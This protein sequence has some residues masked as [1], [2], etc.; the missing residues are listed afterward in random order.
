MA[1]RVTMTIAIRDENGVQFCTLEKVSDRHLQ[2]Q[3][4]TSY[5]KGQPVEFQFALEGYRASVQGDAVI[6]RVAPHEIEQGPTTYALKI[7]A[8]SDKVAKL[9]RQWLYDLA[10]GGGSSNRPHEHHASSISSVVSD[11]SARRAEGERR[12][13]AIEEKRARRQT[14]SVV[15]SIARS[16]T[17]SG[18]RDG[19]GRS[20][21]RKTLRGWAVR[22][23]TPDS[24]PPSSTEPS[25]PPRR[26]LQVDPIVEDID[27]PSVPRAP[28][29]RAPR[30]TP[31]VST[32]STWSTTSTTTG[33][34]HKRK[35]MEVKVADH[36]DPPRVLVRFHDPKRFL[37]MYRDHL[38]RDVLFVRHDGPEL[39]AG[40]P[41]R[42]RIVTPTD[43]VVLCDGTLQAVLPSGVGVVLKLDDDE[44]SLLRRVAASLLRKK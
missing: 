31:P 9:Y 8:V 30:S 21:L 17:V 39:P 14:H 37:A 18:V 7:L 5:V 32:P 13:A 19:V 25:E 26:R 36:T 24:T 33:R 29:Q 35:R 40:S 42:V 15:S 3:S 34:R 4:T 16:G 27:P 28:R 12:L 41:V 38:D 11:A 22:S 20:A 10:H 44:R 43:D 1:I 6:V 23:S 2:V